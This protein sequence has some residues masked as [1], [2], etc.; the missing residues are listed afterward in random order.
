MNNEKKNKKFD[1][2]GWKSYC[3]RLYC[4]AGRW[5]ALGACGWADCAQQAL[6]ERACWACQARAT[7]GSEWPW[8]AGRAGARRASVL[9]GAQGGRRTAL[10]GA[11]ARGRATAGR[12]GRRAADRAGNLSPARRAS[13]TNPKLG[14]GWSL[15]SLAR[16]NRAEFGP[17]RL[18]R[19]LNRIGSG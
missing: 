16:K 10:A 1:A 19:G 11:R 15:I 17:A 18:T 14:P 4:G 8:R 12:R 7:G 9:G 3:N 13:P 6:G 5:Q 2:V